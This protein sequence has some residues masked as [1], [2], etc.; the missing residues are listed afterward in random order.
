MQ[1]IKK[2]QK[3]NVSIKKFDYE[4]FT[5]FFRSFILNELIYKQLHL[6]YKETFRRSCTLTL[7]LS[8]FS[9]VLDADHPLAAVA[10]GA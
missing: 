10:Q 5:G 2:N 6:S 4:V 3:C 9:S 1:V 8:L 7:N